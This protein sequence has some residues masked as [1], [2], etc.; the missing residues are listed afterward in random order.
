MSV[1]QLIT[2]L[3]RKAARVDLQSHPEVEVYLDV[4]DLEDDDADPP[5]ARWK[6]YMVDH[7][8]RRI[9]WLDE[10]DATDMSLETG[11]VSAGSRDIFSAYPPSLIY[12]TMN[13]LRLVLPILFCE[14][15]RP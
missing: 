4:A 9:F 10:F 2:E 15:H 14:L 3:E 1:H 6:Y 8:S 12:H 13:H 7:E 5:E 11:G